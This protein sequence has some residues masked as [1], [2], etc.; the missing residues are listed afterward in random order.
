MKAEL[1]VRHIGLEEALH[2]VAAE[3]GNPAE[4][5][6]T[7]RVAVRRMVAV[8]EEERHTA[9]AVG[10]DHNPAGEADNLAEGADIVPAEARH[11]VAVLEEVRRTVAGPVER[12][13][14]LAVVGHIA[15]AEGEDTG[16]EVVLRTLADYTVD[17]ALVADCNPAVAVGMANV[18][19]VDT[20][21]EVVLRNHLERAGELCK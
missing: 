4:A 20:G 1:A 2:T 21:L 18:F 5:G 9:G 3:V 14:G 7:G 16:L 12:S 10:V 19:V 8:L 15:A 11:M 17:S 6:D 13:I